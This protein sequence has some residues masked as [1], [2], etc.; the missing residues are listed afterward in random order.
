MQARPSS[1]PSSTCWSPGPTP[2]A[3]PTSAA[4][5]PPPTSA[6][7]SPPPCNTTLGG[8]EGGAGEVPSPDHTDSQPSPPLVSGHETLGLHFGSAQKIWGRE[9]EL[10]SP[11]L[12]YAPTSFISSELL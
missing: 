8:P 9:G 12:P 4:T 7:P 3:P 6:R 5:P 10:P 2:P 11:A 1:R